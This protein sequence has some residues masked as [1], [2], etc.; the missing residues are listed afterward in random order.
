MQPKKTAI[1]LQPKKHIYQRIGW[2]ASQPCYVNIIFVI[3]LKLRGGYG[4]TVEKLSRGSLMSC[5]LRVCGG[6]ELQLMM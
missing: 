6:V 4:S 3:L 1:K 2:P 5:L